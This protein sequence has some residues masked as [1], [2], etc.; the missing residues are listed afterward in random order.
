VLTAWTAVSLVALAALVARWRSAPS[1]RIVVFGALSSALIVADIVVLLAEWTI[2]W[3]S[4]AHAVV[5][6]VVVLVM[7]VLGDDRPVP[8]AA[9]RLS[10]IVVLALRVAIAG[11]PS[12][13]A[14]LHVAIEMAAAAFAVA[15][16]YPTLR[17]TRDP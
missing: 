17:A 2:K 13:L 4:I 9:A 16:L 6:T 14:G 12:T 10:L 11:D 1:R 7:A 5:L 3:H 15:A 8:V